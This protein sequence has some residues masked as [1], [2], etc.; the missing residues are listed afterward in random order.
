MDRIR[1][2]EIFVQAVD[3]GSFSAASRN[4]STSVASVTRYV[5]HLEERLGIRLI[6]RSSRKLSLTEGGSAYYARCR[7]ILEDLADADSEVGAAAVQPKGVIKLSVPVSFGI[8]HLAPRWPDF[9]SRHPDIFLELSVTDRLVDLLEDGF[10]AAIR[11]GRLI[12][13]SLVARKLAPARMVVCA[14]PAYLARY[15]TPSV[16]ADLTEH[17]CMSNSYMTPGDDWTLCRQGEAQKVRVTGRVHAN[18]GDTLRAAALAGQGIIA[19][20]SF[21]VGTD[22][23]AGKLVEVLPGW[24]MPEMG[25]YAIYPSRRHMSAKLR[26]L[27]DF[28]T[29][30]FG[31]SPDWDNWRKLAADAA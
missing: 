13:S 26:V 1:A 5:A 27:L 15:G 2:M 6:Q 25:I 16:V 19:Q 24:E 22:L 4:L 23:A 20:P 9:L 21:L 28:L 12:D 10:D 29:Q 14:S 11:V 8:H 17:L 31:P 3:A 18:N 7:Q 30:A